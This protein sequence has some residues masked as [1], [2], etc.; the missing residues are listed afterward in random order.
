MV[1]EDTPDKFTGWSPTSSPNPTK[2][3]VDE[4]LLEK[5]DIESDE[6]EF[7]EIIYRKTKYY[8]DNK[9]KVYEIVNNTNRIR[10]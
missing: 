4:L 2:V 3:N 6:E 1:I 9:N 7:F 10:F 5:P 8:R